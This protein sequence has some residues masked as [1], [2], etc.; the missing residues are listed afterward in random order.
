ME[1]SKL[2][3]QTVYTVT[4]KCTYSLLISRVWYI[5]VVSLIK[6]LILM[7]RYILTLLHLTPILS[8]LPRDEGKGNAFI[9]HSYSVCCLCTS[10]ENKILGHIYIC[11]IIF[12]RYCCFHIVLNLLE[13]TAGCKARKS[14]MQNY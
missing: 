10:D 14:N 6:G 13:N 12:F 4:G 8:S 11:Q 1:T 7:F 2:C 3:L 5:P 9:M